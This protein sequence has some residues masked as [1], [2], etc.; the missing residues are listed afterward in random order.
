[1]LELGL[2]DN[3][4]AR[5]L[6]SDGSYAPVRREPGE[7]SVNSQLKLLG[8]SADEYSQPLS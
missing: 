2:C 7:P 5:E 3:V 6:R 8:V 1:V 4:K